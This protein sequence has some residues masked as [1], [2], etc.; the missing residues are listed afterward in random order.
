M[1]NKLY[2]VIMCYMT[3]QFIGIE[4]FNSGAE[5]RGEPEGHPPWLFNFLPI[6][7]FINKILNYVFILFKS[8]PSYLKNRSVQTL[9]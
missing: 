7:Y 4:S 8:P 3:Y 1:S 2:Y 9:V 6:P 5:G